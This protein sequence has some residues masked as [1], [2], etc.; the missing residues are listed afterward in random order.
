LPEELPEWRRLAAEHLKQIRAAFQ[1]LEPRQ[2]V[3]LFCHDPSALPF[4]WRDEIVRAKLEQIEQTIIGH[5]H[6]NL[7]FRASRW[8]SGMP[9]IRG[10]GHTTLRLSSALSEARR[11]RP[12]KVRLC[13][14]PT[15]IQLLKDGGFYTVELE[16]SATQPAKFQF[17]RLKW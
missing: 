15:G 3:L 12:F 16:E 17:H 4:L 9:V 13:P 1:A 6:T 2:K 14:S 8:L 11:W 10:L 7:V 5:L